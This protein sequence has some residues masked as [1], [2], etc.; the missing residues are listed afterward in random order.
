MT[1]SGKF[2]EVQSSGEEATYT[3]A[4]LL[5]LIGL[6]REGIRQLTEMQRKIIES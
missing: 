2:I 3:E 4:Q 1:G 6:A 5:C